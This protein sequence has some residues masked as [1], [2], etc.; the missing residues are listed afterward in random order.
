MGV[1][2]GWVGWGAGVTRAVKENILRL[3]LVKVH[4]RS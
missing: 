3:I 2:L 4:D 1:R